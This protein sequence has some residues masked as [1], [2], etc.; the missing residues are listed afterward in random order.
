MVAVIGVCW[1]K[2]GALGSR[3]SVFKSDS[4]MYLPCDPGED[5]QPED[6]TYLGGHLPERS[7]NWGGYLTWKVS[8]LL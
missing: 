5:T 4:I 2:L 1:L 6:L 3:R 7:V 8:L